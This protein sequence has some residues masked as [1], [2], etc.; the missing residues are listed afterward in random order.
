MIDLGEKLKVVFNDKSS[1]Y[2]YSRVIVVIAY[3]V[4]F[5]ILGFELRMKF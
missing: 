1:F 2:K 4:H 3:I 5:I